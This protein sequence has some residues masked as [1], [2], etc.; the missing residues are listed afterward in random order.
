MGMTDYAGISYYTY[1]YEPYDY[2]EDYTY[3]IYNYSYSTEYSGYSGVEYASN[4][5]YDTYAYAPNELTYKETSDYMY[6][7][8][9]LLDTHPLV[10]YSYSD[11]YSYEHSSYRNIDYSYNSNELYSLYTPEKAPELHDQMTMPIALTIAVCGILVSSQSLSF[12]T[13]SKSR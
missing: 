3:G 2:A 6:N 10:D 8:S 4:S 1:A 12:S 7:Q 13:Y 11:A 5:D 9:Y